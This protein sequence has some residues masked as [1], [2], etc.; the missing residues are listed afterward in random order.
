M[1]E[2][3]LPQV[4]GYI[5]VCRLATGGMGSVDLAI[6][7]TGTFRRFYAIKRIHAHLRE[8]GEYREMFVDEARVAGLIRHA[9]VVSVLDVGEDE[10]GPFMVMDY[11]DGV[12]LSQVIED[13]AGE[14]IP[15]QIALQV[16]AQ[17]GRGLHAAHEVLS[18]R[19]KR[20]G[21]VHRDV[22]PPNIL[23][24][25]DGT[26]RLT[27]FGIAKAEGRRT[28][29]SGAV[30]KGKIAYMSPEQLQSHDV[31]HRSDL[32]ALGVVVFELLSGERL[33]RE[34]ELLVV[35][36]KIIDAP[37][38]DVGEYRTDIPPPL[39][40]LMFELLSKK[41]ELRPASA[42]EVAQRAEQILATLSA[43]EGPLPVSDWMAPRFARAQ[44]DR[45]TRIESELSRVTG[46]I[47]AAPRTRGR[48][49]RGRRVRKVWFAVALVGLVSALSVAIWWSVNQPSQHVAPGAE[50]EGE[51]GQ[52]QNS[53]VTPLEEEVAQD[54]PAD[55]V[56]EAIV[57]EPSSKRPRAQTKRSA[58][59]RSAARK[60]ATSDKSGEEE[61]SRLWGW[62]RR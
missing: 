50:P 53:Q 52:E 51:M 22:S 40:E 13:L 36:Q 42:Q 23:V 37:I 62:E 18:H 10:H 27:D 55:P 43:D 6:K 61:S 21:L 49:A 48:L 32:F 26:I 5:P 3:T 20:M 19:G 7:G 11:V 15:V 60:K 24:G 39:A 25:F 31:D 8:D 12:S 59:R 29:T 9:N 28:T 47:L 4:S 17:C 2:S 46:I 54:R 16:L 45:R 34:E 30:L 56:I 57:V 44:A 1:D 38:P 14:R 41:R 58:K 33:Y 35:A